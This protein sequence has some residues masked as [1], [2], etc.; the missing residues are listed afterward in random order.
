M[1][2]RYNT[3]NKYI[4]PDIV[5]EADN[6]IEKMHEALLNYKTENKIETVKI[7]ELAL[8][9]TKKE[10]RIWDKSHWH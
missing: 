5:E 1:K 2:D 3:M 6:N 8:N 7:F 4:I 9:K 10:I